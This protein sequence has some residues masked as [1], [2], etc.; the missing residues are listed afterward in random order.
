MSES[1][2][3]RFERELVRSVKS[4]PDWVLLKQAVPYSPK[5]SFARRNAG[6]VDLIGVASGVPIAIEAKVCMRGRF[7]L[8]R[9]TD[10]QREF[11]AQWVRAG[12]SAFV[13]IRY[14]TGAILVPWSV[15]SRWIAD[16]VRSILPSEELGVPVPRAHGVWDLPC[17]V[18][19]LITEY[20]GLNDSARDTPDGS[21]RTT[22]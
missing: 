20:G 11:L 18:H 21:T 22:G 2:G 15:F 16:E 17:A 8:S 7:S 10:P 4:N 19:Q 14:S 12:G 13:A 6:I 9:V 3:V 5:L 1:R